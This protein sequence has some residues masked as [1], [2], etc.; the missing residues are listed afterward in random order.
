M[1]DVAT[2]D[3]DTA[4]P[5]RTSTW[6]WIAGVAVAVAVAAVAVAAF[7]IARDDDNAGSDGPALDSQRIAATQSACE[8]WLDDDTDPGGATPPQGWCTGMTG[9]M[10]DQMADG[11]MTGPMMW[12][13]P[14]AMIDACRQW[15]ATG[16]DGDDTATSGP[17]S[18]GWCDQMVGWMSQHM[19]NW[20]D[21]QDWDDHMD[22]GHWNRM[23]NP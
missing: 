14:Q 8:Q 7:A 17:T 12:G 18:T 1:T 3:Q 20:D 11:S 10:Y 9:W 4:P 23:M 6:K 13:N 15:M 5:P 16:P 22:D 21:W 19:D 2:P